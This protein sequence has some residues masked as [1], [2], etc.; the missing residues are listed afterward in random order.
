MNY[1]LLLFLLSV[2]TNLFAQGGLRYNTQ[3]FWETYSSSPDDVYAYNG[4]EYQ[5]LNIH[6]IYLDSRKLTNRGYGSDPM[7]KIYIRVA[8]G[9][10]YVDKE[11]YLHFLSLYELWRWEGDTSYLP[12]AETADG[13]LILYDINMK[14]GDRYPSVP[15]HEDVIVTNVSDFTLMDGKPR[16]MLTLSNGYKIIA[17]IG[18]INSPGLFL[19]YL[20]PNPDYTLYYREYKLQGAAW[21]ED[22][23]VEPVELYRED[24]SYTMDVRDIGVYPETTATFDLQGRR[25]TQK[26]T[27]GM[28][29]QDGK[30]MVVK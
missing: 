22:G 4:K 5:L 20:N 17:G 19:F 27:K 11:E 30:K 9:R 2:S 25:L 26:P 16:R 10:V 3:M 13:E 24:Q 6:R 28:Y 14:I 23:S 15:G 18:C 29:I 7:A 21:Y 8:D 12:Y 1:Y